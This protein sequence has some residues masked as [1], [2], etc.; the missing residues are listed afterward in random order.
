[1]P[2]LRKRLA[3]QEAWSLCSHG[4]SGA[5]A[6][7]AAA[8]PALESSA[9]GECSRGTEVRRMQ[10]G[11]SLTAAHPPSPEVWGLLGPRHFN[12]SDTAQ[13]CGIRHRLL[14]PWHEGLQC[15]CCQPSAPLILMGGPDHPG[16]MLTVHSLCTAAHVAPSRSP[17][18]AQ[19]VTLPAECPSSLLS[20]SS[21]SPEFL[22][23]SQK[24]RIW[25][26]PNHHLHVPHVS[27]L[28]HPPD[29]YPADAH[30]IHA[31][32]FRKN[33]SRKGVSSNGVL[34]YTRDVFIRESLKK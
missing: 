6:S 11:G 2:G 5:S 32:A 19:S 23:R 3:E 29:T 31:S 12:L 21:S 22:F 9:L 8:L 14:E 7:A 25:M 20:P 13:S 33:S 15:S 24:C 30:H 1:M 28:Q 18:S 4:S 26:L 16:W 17:S 10:E 27:Q 34:V